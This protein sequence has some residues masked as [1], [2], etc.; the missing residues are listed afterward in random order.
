MIAS[1]FCPLLQ[2]YYCHSITIIITVAS[3]KSENKMLRRKFGPK[4]QDGMLPNE[5]L[6]SLYSS[7]NVTRVIES[8]ITR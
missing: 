2:L 3:G 5:E 8:K 6:N 4:R 1:K 7:K